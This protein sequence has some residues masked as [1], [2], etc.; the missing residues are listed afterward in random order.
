MYICRVNTRGFSGLKTKK[1]EKEQHSFAVYRLPC[2]RHQPR[3][4]G[5][6]LSMP[7]PPGWRWRNDTK[8]YR[9]SK[10]NMSKKRY[11]LNWGIPK[12]NVA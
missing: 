2:F 10:S 1:W 9:N 6:A 8:G 12:E 11:A 5:W 7:Y 3:R 4:P